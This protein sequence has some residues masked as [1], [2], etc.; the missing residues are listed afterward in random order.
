VTFVPDQVALIAPE[1]ATA[2]S[3][4]LAFLLT[5]AEGEV[6]WAPWILFAG[7]TA[8]DN[9][10]SDEAVLGEDRVGFGDEPQDVRAKDRLLRDEPS[11]RTG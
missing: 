1:A 3:A 7:L 11:S 9:H 10:G 6:H 2:A 5:K 8:P 4:S